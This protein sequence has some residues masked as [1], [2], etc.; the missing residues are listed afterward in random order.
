MKML[1]MLGF[2][3]ALTGCSFA[4]ADWYCNHYNKWHNGRCPA[5]SLGGHPLRM[6][7]DPLLRGL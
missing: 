6:H 3:A 1:K 7:P 5:V 2:G 4:L